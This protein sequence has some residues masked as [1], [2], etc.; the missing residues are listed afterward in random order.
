MTYEKLLEENDKL[1]NENRLLNQKIEKLIENKNFIGISFILDDL[2][3]SKFI[4][5]EIFENILDEI[6]KDRVDKNAQQII[7]MK[8]FKSNED[9]KN[10]ENK[11]LEYENSGNKKGK[12]DIKEN[13]YEKANI[14]IK[15]NIKETLTEKNKDIKDNKLEK[16]KEK[17]NEIM[18][19]E[20]NIKEKS[21]EKDIY[22]KIRTNRYVRYHKTNNNTRNINNDNNILNEDINSKDKIYIKSNPKSLNLESYKIADLKNSK[23][24]EGKEIINERKTGFIRRRKYL[25]EKI[26]NIK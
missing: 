23:V 20:N 14:E 25:K 10:K 16:E 6:T 1:K 9:V 13:K 24:E 15:N 7:T 2:E 5:D 22:K 18:K 17:D 8:C 11:I 19:T 4:D 12:K 3:G 26:S 21:I